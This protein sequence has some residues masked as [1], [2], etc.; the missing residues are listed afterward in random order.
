MARGLLG[1][2]E[3]GGGSWR[4]GGC[5][6][7]MSGDLSPGGRMEFFCSLPAPIPYVLVSFD[8]DNK[9]RPD[10][11]QGNRRPTG[12]G[13]GLSGLQRPASAMRALSATPGVWMLTIAVEGHEDS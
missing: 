3:S 1:D 12:A 6:R 7:G 2:T 5:S 13:G 4:G 10:D 9:P 11:W 8:V